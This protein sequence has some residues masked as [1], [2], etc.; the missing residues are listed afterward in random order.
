MVPAPCDTDLTTDRLVL[1]PWSVPEITAV[2]AGARLPHWAADFPSE[3][4]RIRVGQLAADPERQHPYGHRQLLERDTGLVVG[5]IGLFWPPTDGV[6]EFGYGVVPSR[7]RL[8]YATEAA[9]AIVAFALTLPGVRTVV[10]DVD[11]ANVASVGV[12]E[13]A[14]LRRTPTAV[15]S[16]RA[17]G[18]L[19]RYVIGA[20]DVVPGGYGTRPEGGAR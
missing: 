12:L 9:R 3:V 14:G 4:D 20:H 10:A 11:P 1:R 7:R 6:V 19:R 18:E 8:G 17:D 2:V 16:A 5:A 15:R 13:K